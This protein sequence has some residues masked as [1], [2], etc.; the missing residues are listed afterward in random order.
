MNNIFN[1]KIGTNEIAIAEILIKYIKEHQELYEIFISYKKLRE[2]LC[3][4]KGIV[5]LPRSRELHNS[6]GNLSEYCYSKGLPFITG[7]VVRGRSK[8]PG[9]GYYRMLKAYK[10]NDAQIEEETKKAQSYKNWKKLQ[11]II[12]ECLTNV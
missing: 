3:E 8:K 5:F 2:L 12:N 9:P 7:M 11:E 1:N 10:L 4:E 6:L